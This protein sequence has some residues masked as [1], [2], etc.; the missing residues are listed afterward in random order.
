MSLLDPNEYADLRIVFVGGE[1]FSSELVDQWAPGRR[2]FNGYG[3]TECTVT[4]T[5]HECEPGQAGQPPMGLPMRGHVAHVVNGADELQVPGLIG[6]LVVG[7]PDWPSGTSTDRKRR[8]QRSSTTRS[9]R[10]R[11]GACTEP[12]TSFAVTSTAT[13]STSAGRTARSRSVECALSWVRWRH[14][15]VHTPTCASATPA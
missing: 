2:F 13:W 11:M 12:V 8:Q 10:R 9:A 7:E 1:P 15:C 4:M 5:V 14:N 6:E 3:P